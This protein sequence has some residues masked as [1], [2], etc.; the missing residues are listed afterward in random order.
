[1]SS[2]GYETPPVSPGISR[3]SL[4]FDKA[5]EK[6]TEKWDDYVEQLAHLEV[7][8]ASQQEDEILSSPLLT[9]PLIEGSPPTQFGLFGASVSEDQASLAKGRLYHNV[10]CPS[11]VFICGSQGSGKSNTLACLLEN[12]LI[13]SRLGQLP[14]PLTGIVFHYDSFVSNSGGL[15][16]EAAFLASH[17]NVSVRVLCAPTNIRT[18]KACLSPRFAD[19]SEHRLADCQTEHLQRGSWGQD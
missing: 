11:S 19:C 14:H 2:D 6:S 3:P 4:D 13:P 16:C 12:C 15:P 9:V 5:R 7:S 8:P 1:M 18:I 17:E 10:A